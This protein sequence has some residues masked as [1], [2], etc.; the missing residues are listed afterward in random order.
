MA[1][2]GSNN[3]CRVTLKKGYLYHVYSKLNCV[4]N[5]YGIELV[6]LTR[7]ASN[8]THPYNFHSLEVVDRVSETQLQAGEN[9]KYVSQFYSLEVVGRDSVTQLH[10]SRQL[11]FINSAF[12]VNQQ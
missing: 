3:I 5:K 7:F 6:R 10:V 9:Y 1:L 2:H 8:Y 4:R 12:R 11:N